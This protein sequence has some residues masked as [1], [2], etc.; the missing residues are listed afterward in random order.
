MTDINKASKVKLNRKGKDFIIL[1]DPNKALEFKKG[2]LKDIREALVADTIF[3]DVAKAEKASEHDMQ[4]LFKTEDIYQVAEIILKQGKLEL[5]TGQKN[6]EREELKK[7]ITSIIARNAVDPRTGL[8]HPLQRIESAMEE[9]K[10]NIQEGKEAEE[11]VNDIVSQL[12][13][14]L[15]I[16]FEKR[17][18]EIIIPSS[19]AGQSF[20]ILKN[21]S[22][23]IKNEY[24]GDGSLR[25]VVEIAAG[26]QDEFFSE[27]N[28][29]CHGQVES[30]LL[31]KL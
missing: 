18:I 29:L 21:Y 23:V 17:R 28:K 8:P 2:K 6:K 26:M 12:A 1:V 20:R 22:D 31:E 14:V 19:F 11:Q 7:R 27:L 16:K 4:N 30:K 3:K 24:L 13:P 25:A 5:T 15:P 9:A 10:V